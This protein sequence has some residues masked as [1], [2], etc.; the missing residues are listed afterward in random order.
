[1]H[2]NI[3]VYV[4]STEVVWN[5]LRPWQPCMVAQYRRGQG[6][7]KD[8]AR[9]LLRMMGPWDGTRT[10]P[11]NFHKRWPLKFR[12]RLWWRT[13][14]LCPKI[15]IFIVHQTSQDSGNTAARRQI[16]LRTETTQVRPLLPLGCWR[17]VEIMELWNYSREVL[18]VQFQSQRRNTSRTTDINEIHGVFHLSTQNASTKKSTTELT[19]RKKLQDHRRSVIV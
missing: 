13:K 12:K 14:P 17:T 7:R 1:M 3:G 11:W 9:H 4:S 19:N 6:R 10:R 15:Q 2:D 16:H 8:W 18:V 5:A